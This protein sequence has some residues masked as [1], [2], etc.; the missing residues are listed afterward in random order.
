MPMTMMVIEDSYVRHFECFQC[1]VS[2]YT[3]SNVNAKGALA[4]C[5]RHFGDTKEVKIS[6]VEPNTLEEK[7]KL[8]RKKSQSINRVEAHAA[9]NA[10]TPL[11]YVD[12]IV[13]KMMKS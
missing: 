5:E 9:N 6:P 2:A 4:A 1:N 8:V 13:A 12:S 11:G 3:S 10:T 7:P